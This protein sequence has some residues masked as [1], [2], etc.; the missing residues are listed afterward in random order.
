[1][2]P[3]LQWKIII[4]YSE[5][6]SVDLGTQHAMRMRHIVSVFCLVVQYFSTLSHKRHDFLNKKKVIDYKLCVLSFST[7]LPETL[8]IMKR[9]D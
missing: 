1:M 3:L 6:V 8:F 4:T 7:N 5:C 2:Q 9:T